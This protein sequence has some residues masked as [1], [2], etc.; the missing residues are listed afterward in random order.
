MGL[1]DDKSPT[2]AAFRKQQKQLKAL[3]ERLKDPLW[4]PDFGPA[5]MNA[6]SG[7]TV[8]GAR[9][10]LIAYNVNLNTRDRRLANVVAQNKAT[11]SYPRFR[12]LSPIK[13]GARNL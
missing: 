9:E 12:Q 5:K 4:A 13:L 3:E 1:L 7:A 10:F 6:R 8:I 11:D 2:A